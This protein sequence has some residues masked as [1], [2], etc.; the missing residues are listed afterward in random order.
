MTSI[1]LLEVS[2]STT[3]RNSIIAIPEMPANRRPNFNP[4]FL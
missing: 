2:A 4:Y 1:V 3:T